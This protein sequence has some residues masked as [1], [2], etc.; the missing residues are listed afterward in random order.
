MKKRIF[1]LISLIF[2]NN[3]NLSFS[4]ER[5]DDINDN[6]YRPSFR[7]A[8]NK[9]LSGGLC[10]IVFENSYNYSAENESIPGQALSE[11]GLS[12]G[13]QMLVEGTF[14]F[15]HWGYHKFRNH[16]YRTYNFMDL[17]RQQR[18][19]SDDI[20]PPKIH[21]NHEFCWNKTV[22]LTRSLTNSIFSVNSMVLA[23][24]NENALIRSGNFL[25]FS[26]DDCSHEAT[27]LGCYPIMIHG[28]TCLALASVAYN[29][30]EFYDSCT[31]TEIRQGDRPF[32]GAISG[33]AKMIAGGQVFAFYPPRQIYTLLD[34][35]TGKTFNVTIGSP[36]GEYIHDT[37]VFYGA[38]QLFSN[39]FQMLT[40][41]RN[42][43]MGNAK[44]LI[45]SIS[46]KDTVQN[47][48]LGT[49][50]SAFS[51]PETPKQNPRRNRSREERSM[52]THSPQGGKTAVVVPQTPPEFTEQTQQKEEKRESK[53]GKI[54]TKGTPNL[55][56]GS[57]PSRNKNPKSLHQGARED[58]PNGEGASLSQMN[59]PARQEML[60]LIND[61]RKFNAVKETR[62]EDLLSQ[63]RK[64][65]QGS[66]HNIDG[67]ERAIVFYRGDQRISIKF[68]GPH[69][70]DGSVYQGW[71][72][73]RVLNAI[74]T[75]YMY[76]WDEE[77]I[78][79]Y[80]TDHSITRFYQVPVHLSS[81]LWTRPHI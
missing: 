12:V 18:Q 63:T 74:E 38:Y 41:S 39:G 62:I 43:I 7:S 52:P 19:S 6:Y 58:I 36:L 35:A 8:C 15:L 77:S 71:K 59:N 21:K 4:V 27:L 13:Y 9:I 31:Q 29:A 34:T 72:L 60:T 37:L 2:F 70:T 73:K 79:K 69:G 61:L 1:I 45:E 47:S 65:L 14:E 66:I 48:A 33:Y 17:S 49:N 23:L 50:P 5:I 75:A 11:V 53:K 25:K 81:I 24:I 20:R 40:N 64:F 76:N 10:Y 68:E 46:S 78:R 3:A 42:L 44:V 57:A 32:M 30:K 54:K 80:M 51:L 55:F 26:F 22:N 56:K 67:S 28:F 16:C